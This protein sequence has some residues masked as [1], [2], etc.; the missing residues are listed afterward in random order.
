MSLLD[1]LLAPARRVG[2]DRLGDLRPAYPPVAFEID[3]DE[4][5]MVRVR[6]RRRGKPTLEAHQSRPVADGAVGA[7]ILR[8]NVGAPEE[9]A[10]RV[11]ELF[12]TS[13]TKPGRVSIVLPDNLAKVSIVSLPERPPARRQLEEIL[14]FRLR[15]SVPFRLEESVISHQVLPGDGPGIDVLVAVMLRSVVEQYES[16]FV[17]AGAVPGLVDL[18]TLSVFNLC[19]AAMARAHAEDGRDVA[20]LNCAR[21]YFSLAIARGARLLFFRCKT[22]QTGEDP[23]AVL[24]AMSREMA[25]SLSYYQDRLSGQGVGTVFVRT[26]SV[27]AG[28]L[29][30]MLGRAGLDR[31]V[32]VDPAA[33]VGL[34]PGLGLDPEVAQRL[35]PSVGAAAGRAA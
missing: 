25:T 5:T 17:A 14:R 26:T 27:E 13:G 2:L 9:I 1:S 4:I 35:A 31:V 12:E 11:R 22:H 19:R 30:E 32:P 8:P 28:A 21:G 34:A 29:S 10:R 7:S 23:A 15:R 6:P 16:A 20:L 33:S 18:S 3:R 24:A